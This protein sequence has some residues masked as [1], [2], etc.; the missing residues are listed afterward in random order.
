VITQRTAITVVSPAAI[1]SASPEITVAALDGHGRR[2]ANVL[3]YGEIVLGDWVINEPLSSRL[4]RQ[5]SFDAA[6]Y[7]PD[8]A[9]LCRGFV[10]ED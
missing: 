6:G 1:S 8:D 4:S 5:V 7:D 9:E 10:H 3:S 2:R